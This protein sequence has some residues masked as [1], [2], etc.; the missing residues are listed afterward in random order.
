[1]AKKQTTRWLGQAPEL[2]AP[3]RMVETDV[4]VCGGGLAGVAAVRAAAENGVRVI[5]FEKCPTV[6]G[7]SGQFEGP[8]QN[9]HLSPMDSFASQ[10]N[11]DAAVQK[12]S[13]VKA[14][15]LEELVEKMGLPAENALFFLEIH[16]VFLRKTAFFRR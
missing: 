15:T 12:G 9:A 4:I 10:R 11:I 14:D 8:D 2:A 1:M 16:K 3:Q 7:R 13:T 5:L 6:Q